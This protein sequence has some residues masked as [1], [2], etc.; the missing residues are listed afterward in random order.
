MLIRKPLLKLQSDWENK[1]LFWKEVFTQISCR[2]YFCRLGYTEVTSH[3]WLL[4][5]FCWY[6]WSGAWRESRR[7]EKAF[8]DL[9]TKAWWDVPERGQVFKQHDCKRIP[10][11]AE[12]FILFPHLPYHQAADSQHEALH[13]ASFLAIYPFSLLWPAVSASEMCWRQ[14]ILCAS[15]SFNRNQQSCF[16][17]QKF[18]RKGRKKVLIWSPLND[19]LLQTYYV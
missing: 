14:L 4:F 16:D 11:R 10:C 13:V 2:S 15:T 18:D 17:N 8:R 5:W 6:L 19:H 9:M 12:T 1:R 3:R 7:A